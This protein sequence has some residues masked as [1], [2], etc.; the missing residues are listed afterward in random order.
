MKKPLRI[1]S[2]MIRKRN[3]KYASLFFNFES[4]NPSQNEPKSIQNHLKINKRPQAASKRLPKRLHGVKTSPDPS[5]KTAPTRLKT[6]PRPPKTTPR[7][8]QDHPK[9]LQDS[10]KKQNVGK[11]SFL[12]MS[13]T[14]CSFLLFW[15][16][17]TIISKH[18]K[19][20]YH[21]FQRRCE[22]KTN[23][24]VLQSEARSL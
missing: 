6:P 18:P 10:P 1:H 23:E 14:K 21:R 13:H 8:P 16:P 12:M 17:S 5:P 22:T 24:N 20:F 15:G 2:K 9:T 11:H 4:Q 3:K 7:L 19:P